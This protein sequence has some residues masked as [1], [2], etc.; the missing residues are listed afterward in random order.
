MAFTYA[1]NILST[2]MVA[3]EVHFAPS[4]KLGAVG[5]ALEK[6]VAI[7]ARTLG[8]GVV[9]VTANDL[10]AERLGLRDGKLNVMSKA[11][12]QAEQKKQSVIWQYLVHESSDQ[13][14]MSRGCPSA[15]RC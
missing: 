14:P 12:E 8:R 3:V 7:G 2:H 9:L 11:F 1:R 15:K 5:C 6:V 4:T 13:W 10:V